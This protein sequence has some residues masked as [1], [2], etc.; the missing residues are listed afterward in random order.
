MEKNTFKF[1]ENF[2][3]SYD[4]DS[5][6]GYIIEVDAEYLKSLH[7]LYSYFSF[8]SK[9]L[10][11]KKCNKLVCNL[12]CSHKSFKTNTKARI[13][14][15]KVHRVTHLSEKMKTCFYCQILF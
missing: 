9:K 6:K 3:K 14:F 11:I 2:I 4:K 5:N 7:D 13:S 15:E 1:D 8:L 10:K 12:H